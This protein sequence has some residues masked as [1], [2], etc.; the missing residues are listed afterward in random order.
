MDPAAGAGP[1][2]RNRP[3]SGRDPRTSASLPIVVLKESQ[4]NT[5]E[6]CDKIRATVEAADRMEP[7]SLGERLDLRRSSSSGSPRLI[8]RRA[9]LQPRFAGPMS[10]KNQV[11]SPIAGK[12]EQTV[13]TN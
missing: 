13:N 1:R 11:K 5:V 10:G 8:R 6:V 3:V 9:K 2:C 7:V 4:A 12:N